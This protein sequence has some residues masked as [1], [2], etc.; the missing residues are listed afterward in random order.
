M[1]LGRGDGRQ[2][3]RAVKSLEEPVARFLR[4]RGFF[5]EHVEARMQLN[6]PDASHAPPIPPGFGLQRLR[7][8]EAIREF[9]RLYELAF[10]GRPWYQ[11]YSDEAEVAAELP[12]ASDLL[13]LC[14]GHEPVGFI[15]LRWPAVDVVEMEP[16]GIVPEYQGRGLARPFLLAGIRQAADQGAKTVTL[17]VWE[18]NAAALQLYQSLGF[19]RTNVVTYLAHNL[20]PE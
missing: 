1:A 10:A 8:S 13:F 5:V 3:S 6:R 19:R 2:L 14:Y 11:P 17:G 9:L 15:W 16:V 18:N 4:K 12:D 7:K 20:R